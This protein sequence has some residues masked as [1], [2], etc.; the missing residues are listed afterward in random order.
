VNEK[1]MIFVELDNATQEKIVD[2]LND[3]IATTA[4][5]LK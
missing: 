2:L 5:I 3:H 4:N 1:V